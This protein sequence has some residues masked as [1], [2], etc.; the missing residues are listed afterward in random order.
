M[1]LEKTKIRATV[2][3]SMDVTKGLLVTLK[4]LILVNS[5]E[6]GLT[7]VSP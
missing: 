2:D 3:Q 6:K 7:E 5:K 1:L 4:E